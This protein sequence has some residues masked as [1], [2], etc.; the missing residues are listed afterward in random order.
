METK[1]LLFEY[2]SVSICNNPALD[3]KQQILEEI[4]IQHS[5]GWVPNYQE[6]K[7]DFLV[8]WFKRFKVCPNCGGDCPRT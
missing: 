5:Q 4:N 3:I 7:G 8:T 1:E 2:K 6:V